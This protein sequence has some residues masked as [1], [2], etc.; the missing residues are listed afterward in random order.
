MG[1]MVCALAGTSCVAS[2]SDDEEAVEA[3]EAVDGKADGY[4]SEIEP[5]AFRLTA[6]R[7]L[8]PHFYVRPFLSCSDLTDTGA[9]GEPS[10]NAMLN[11]FINEDDPDDPNGILDLSVLLL[12][13]PFDA[14]SSTSRIDVGSGDCTAPASSTRCDLD[15]ASQ[16]SSTRLTNRSSGYCFTADRDHLSPAAYSPEPYAVAGPCFATEPVD[17]TLTLGWVDLPLKDVTIGGAYGGTGLRY[18]SLRGFL[19]ERDADRLIMPDY[20]P[21]VG[22][23]PLSRM[24][25]GGNGNC[26]SHD[27]RDVHDGERG[28]WLY[29]AFYAEPV[30]YVGP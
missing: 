27:D 24:F 11:G 9:F 25:P 20:L 26:A 2:T 30:D 23:Y 5:D 3:V 18:G 4:Q 14:F 28:W 17:A 16:P 12:F 8:E 1:A 6:V 29:V 13:R 21:V 22:G 15:P 10:I 7:V 19:T